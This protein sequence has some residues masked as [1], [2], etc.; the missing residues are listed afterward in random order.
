MIRC[1]SGIYFSHNLDSVTVVL[2]SNLGLVFKPGHTQNKEFLLHYFPVICVYYYR[3]N[4]K[5]TQIIH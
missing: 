1:I 4:K 2:R 3:S 5:V